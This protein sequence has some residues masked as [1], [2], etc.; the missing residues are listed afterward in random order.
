MLNSTASAI[1]RMLE[2]P[3]PADLLPEAMAAA[4][5]GDP[6]R[7]AQ[8]TRDTLEEWRASRLIVAT[9]AEKL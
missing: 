7:I 3:I 4:Y 1:W 9:P 8:D 6:A 2:K 5:S